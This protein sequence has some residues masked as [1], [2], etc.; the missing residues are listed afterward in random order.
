MRIG[1]KTDMIGI[2]QS[3]PRRWEILIMEVAKLNE[4]SISLKATRD[5]IK[6]MEGMKDMLDQLLLLELNG[7]NPVD[8]KRVF[9]LGLQI[10]G[11]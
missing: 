8:I 9:I 7:L 10:V 5:N 6:I 2:M 4:S 1:R 11:K 3:G